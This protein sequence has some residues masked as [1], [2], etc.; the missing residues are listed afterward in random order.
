MLARIGPPHR[1]RLSEIVDL[2]ATNSAE[3][4]HRTVHLEL[5]TTLALDFIAWG[6]VAIRTGSELS[7]CRRRE[8]PLCISLID[9]FLR[10]LAAVAQFQQEAWTA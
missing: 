8:T 2:V 9:E 4:T 7:L 5:V 6:E 1:S 10:D 3:V